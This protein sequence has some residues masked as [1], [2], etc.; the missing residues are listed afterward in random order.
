[1]GN[2]ILSR[3]MNSVK[4]ALY[5]N[6]VTTI[7]FWTDKNNKKLSSLTKDL[8]LICDKKGLVRCEG[9]FKNTPLPYD[10]KTPILLNSN[11]RL[12]ELILHKI[13]SQFNKTNSNWSKTKILDKLRI[14]LRTKLRIIHFTQLVSTILVLY[15]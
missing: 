3:L 8:N 12:A 15:L 13:V 14:M 6:W 2:L 9:R 4:N 7:L 5:R 11:H 1:M 10:T